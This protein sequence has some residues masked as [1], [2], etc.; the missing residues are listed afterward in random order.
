MIPINAGFFEPKDY[1]A[2]RLHSLLI[3]SYVRMGIEKGVSSCELGGNWGQ[4]LMIRTVSRSE[5]R[6][7]VVS[8]NLSRQRKG[9]AAFSTLQDTPEMA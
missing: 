2:Q 1:P 6:V 3:G 5:F 9:E 8:E 4:S 7:R